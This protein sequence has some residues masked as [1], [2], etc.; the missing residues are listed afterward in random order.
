MLSDPVCFFTALECVCFSHGERHIVNNWNIRQ[1]RNQK[2]VRRERREEQVGR[3]LVANPDV[4][5][6]YYVPYTE[7]ESQTRLVFIYVVESLYLPIK[8]RFAGRKRA[9]SYLLALVFP[10]MSMRIVTARV[11]SWQIR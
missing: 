6:Q 8:V 11:N 4:K 7:R 5:E 3:I 2:H 10:I 9:T 1:C